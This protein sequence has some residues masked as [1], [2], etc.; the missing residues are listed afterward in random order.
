MGLNNRQIEQYSSTESSYRKKQLS[1]HRNPS[2]RPVPLVLVLVQQQLQYWFSQGCSHQASESLTIF[3]GIFQTMGSHS[4]SR[5]PLRSEKERSAKQQKR[6][7]LLTTPWCGSFVRFCFDFYV[8]VV[9]TE[10]GESWCYV[11]ASASLG[12]R[13]FATLLLVYNNIDRKRRGE[14]VACRRPSKSAKRPG[15]EARRLTI[16][17]DPSVYVARS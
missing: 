9:F 10:G 6:R 3:F 1:L 2:L 12:K 15:R 5:W 7:R 4:S 17:A 11:S 16:L 8:V 14:R 13:R